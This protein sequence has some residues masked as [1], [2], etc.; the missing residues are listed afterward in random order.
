MNVQIL[1][2]LVVKA[3]KPVTEDGDHQI[4]IRNEQEKTEINPTAKKPTKH[5]A[6]VSMRAKIVDAKKKNEKPNIKRGSPKKKGNIENN[7]RS[8][9]KKKC[10]GRPNMKLPKE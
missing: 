1:G 8:N 2:K 6:S 5:G 7:N 9:T 10:N 3:R 4:H